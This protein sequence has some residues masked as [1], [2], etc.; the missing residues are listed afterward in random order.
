MFTWTTLMSEIQNTYVHTTGG[1]VMF[2]SGL[3]GVRSFLCRTASA[4][5]TFGE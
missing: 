4:R 5:R 3:T 2:L 1:T